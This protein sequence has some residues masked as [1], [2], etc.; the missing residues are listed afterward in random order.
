MLDWNRFPWVSFGRR[1]TPA[2]FEL[3]C[4]EQRERLVCLTYKPHFSLFINAT[5][6]KSV[7]ELA[8]TMMSLE[9][10]TYPH[11][12]A[13]LWV[14]SDVKSALG[15]VDTRIGVFEAPT[16]RF[17]EMMRKT[18]FLPQAEWSVAFRGGDILSP[19]ALFEFASE[20]GKTRASTDSCPELFYPQEVI[21]GGGSKA[22]VELLSKCRDSVPTLL[23]F[24]Y[25]GRCFLFHEA[26][27]R[28]VDGAV[29]PTELSGFGEYEWLLKARSLTAS[30]SLVPG[31]WYYRAEKYSQPIFE[32]NVGASHRALT[33]LQVPAHAERMTVNPATGTRVC[34]HIADPERHKISVVICFRDKTRMTFDCV[35]RLLQCKGE[36]PLEVI[37]VDNGSGD[38]EAR[39]IR[40][41]VS[42]SPEAANIRILEF[43][44]AFNFGRMNNWAVSKHATGDI[45]LFLNND[46]ELGEGTSLDVWA[47]WALYPGIGTVGICL[48]FPDGGV[49]HCGIRASFGGRSH[50]FRI[51]NSHRND[52]LTTLGREVFANTFAACMVRKSVFIDNGALDDVDMANGFG[53]VAF[54]FELR[55]KGLKNM[56]LGYF[57]G[58]HA[59]GAS[60]GHGYE[61][62]E[63]V[64]LERRFSEGLFEMLRE[65]LS[66]STMPLAEMDLTAILLDTVKGQLRSM[67]WLDPIKPTLKRLV[68]RVWPRQA[69]LPI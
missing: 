47:A 58:T 7:D 63:E 46:V 14:S 23:H 24:N 59:E 25:V 33:E 50:L 45:V 65:D 26:L 60:R 48:R 68:H 34:P 6:L 1:E 55:R 38:E 9:K 53:D 29:D 11:W 31:Y 28:R 64:R 57:S 36:I 5:H 19:A 30:F 27:A 32:S 69:H 56:Y 17:G 67:P 21:L 22:G 54:N 44:E 62:W 16:M 42:S 37:L 8:P 39:W 3:K 10:Q 4:R 43:P 41:Q 12:N 2:E 35:K 18:Q 61:Y 40:A 13:F 51:G 66:S 15:D 20:M 49:Q 52:R